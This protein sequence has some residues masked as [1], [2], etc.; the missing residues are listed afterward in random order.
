MENP[1][2]ETPAPEISAAPITE[3]D[4][5]QSPEAITENPAPEPMPE[6]MPEMGMGKRKIL[7][8]M[9]KRK[10]QAIEQL[11]DDELEELGEMLST[12]INQLEQQDEI[13][14]TLY[15]TF[16]EFPEVKGFVSDLVKTGNLRLAVIRNF[17]TEAL[18]LQEGDDDET[19]YKT[20]MEG[21]KK[22]KDEYEKST[23]EIKS[24]MDASVRI[25]E[26]FVTRKKLDDERAEEFMS[27]I[28]EL[29]SDV[30]RAKLT[31]EVLE[32]F[33]KGFKYDED[34]P[35]AEQRGKAQ[36][37][38][39]QIEPE[40]LEESKETLPDLGTSMG[41]Q[42]AEKKSKSPFSSMADQYRKEYGV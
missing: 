9:S 2:I 39:E 3:T 11:S 41:K 23:A 38:V 17:D 36:G 13:F 32:L 15:N 19:E 20:A 14:R 25:V 4:M 33:F 6:T 10:G 21:R 1:I 16:E 31:T 5:S 27:K 42:P 7:D 29:L 35:E 30:A 18:S 34:M 40:I 24:N 26:D 8:Y 12:D 37:R 22:A 28:D